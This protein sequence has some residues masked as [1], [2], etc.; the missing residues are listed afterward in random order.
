MNALKQLRAALEAATTTALSLED[1]AHRRHRL[2]AL[3]I[4]R[5][6]RASELADRAQDTVR[7]LNT[8][9]KRIEQP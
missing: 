5:A 8:A 4:E 3:A 6:N 2:A 1:E 9:I 7:N